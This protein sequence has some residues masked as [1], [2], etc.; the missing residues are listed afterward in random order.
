MDGQLFLYDSVR[1]P[2]VLHYNLRCWTRPTLC[3]FS[4]SLLSAPLKSPPS[5][6]HGSTMPLRRSKARDHQPFIPAALQDAKR[7]PIAQR[8]ETAFHRQSARFAHASC[9]AI[10]ATTFP[11]ASPPE[12]TQVLSLSRTPT[13]ADAHSTS[14]ERQ[15]PPDSHFHPATEE[16]ARGDGS[17]RPS[18]SV[19]HRHGRNSRAPKTLPTRLEYSQAGTA[20]HSPLAKPAPLLRRRPTGF[21]QRS[22]PIQ[23]CLSAMRLTAEWESV[24]RSRNDSLVRRS[25]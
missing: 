6:P 8:S 7:R 12:A 20:A 9:P 4:F 22:T 1:C 25:G 5:P 13:A 16:R 17:P 14:P 15:P 3:I 19:G 21:Q 23:K 2:F 24:H 10:P 11:C 18:S